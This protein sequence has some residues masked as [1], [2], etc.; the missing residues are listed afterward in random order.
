[1]RRHSSCRERYYAACHGAC[2]HAR[3][4]AHIHARGYSKSNCLTVPIAAETLPDHQSWKC[5]RGKWLSTPSLSSPI[6]ARCIYIHIYT[7]TFL[8][9]WPIPHSIPFFLLHVSSC[10]FGE[11]DLKHALLQ[12]VLKFTISWKFE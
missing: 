8:L 12:I 4:H 11:N 2:M 3:T 9:F 7:S 6:N 10:S 1:M 5:S